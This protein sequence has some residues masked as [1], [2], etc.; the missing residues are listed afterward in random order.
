MEEGKPAVRLI[1][2]KGKWVTTMG[3]S[4]KGRRDGE[5]KA[6]QL[7]EIGPKS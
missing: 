5:R 4:E 7:W 3:Q 1:W 2:R 6:N